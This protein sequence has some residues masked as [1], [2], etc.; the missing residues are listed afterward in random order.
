MKEIFIFTVL[1]LSLALQSNSQTW[2]IST[3]T[4]K[5]PKSIGGGESAMGWINGYDT[6]DIIYTVHGDNKIR[7]GYRFVYSK[8]GFYIDDLTTWPIFFDKD[9]R[10]VYNVCVWQFERRWD[11]INHLLVRI[12]ITGYL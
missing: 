6:A 5:Y 1:V 9:R 12:K 8:N 11:F 3:D 7:V 10:R 2:K 4:L